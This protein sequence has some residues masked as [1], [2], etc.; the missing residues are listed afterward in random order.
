ML[1]PPIL[2]YAIFYTFMITRIADLKSPKRMEIID[3]ASQR[4]YLHEL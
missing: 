4:I 2:D 3:L 1:I